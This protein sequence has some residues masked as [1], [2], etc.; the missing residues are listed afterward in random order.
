MD[1]Y[2]NIMINIITSFFISKLVNPRIEF[3]NQELVNALLKNV[4]SP[5]VETVHLFV[6]DEISMRKLTALFADS[7]NSKK[8]NIISVGKQP[9]YYDLFAYAL[10]L[11]DKICMV[12]NS[13]IYIDSCETALIDRLNNEPTLLYALT[14]HEY[15]MSCPLIN[16]YQGS[17]DSFIFKSPLN[18]ISIETLKFPQNVWGSENKLISELYKQQIVIKNP[19]K[20]I[21][22]VHLHQSAI[23]EQNRITIS[24]HT[25]D[26]PSVHFP[27]VH[28]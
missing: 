8:I 17:H 18:N 19:C 28:L 16:S 13:D 2:I 4:S 26:N 14:R 21:K 10:N 3:R 25:Y 7:I 6:D 15:D 9:L 20:Q 5:F 12:T 23:R 27:P 1:Y 11:K 22:I 24:H